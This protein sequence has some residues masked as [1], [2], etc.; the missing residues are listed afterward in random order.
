MTLGKGFFLS[1]KVWG[2]VF[3][4]VLKGTKKTELEAG[5]LENV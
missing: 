4:V 3:F 5:F 1:Q 2:G